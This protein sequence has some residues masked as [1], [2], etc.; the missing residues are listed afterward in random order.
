MEAEADKV[1]GQTAARAAIKG[2]D[3]KAVCWRGKRGNPYGRRACCRLRGVLRA[4]SYPDKKS[5]KRPS[6]D[7]WESGDAVRI[8]GCEQKNRATAG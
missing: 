7:V 2:L 3:A 8:T 4:V 1:W 6:S 5:A